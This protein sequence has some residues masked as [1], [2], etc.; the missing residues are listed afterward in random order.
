MKEI[1]CPKCGSVFTVDESGYNEIVAS[2]RDDEFSRELAI[3]EKA[4]KEK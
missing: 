1:K 2:I 3:R 4:L